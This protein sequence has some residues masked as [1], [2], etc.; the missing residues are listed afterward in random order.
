M[1]LHDISELWKSKPS[2]SNG[3]CLEN[4]WGLIAPCEFKSHGFRIMTTNT[5]TVTPQPRRK[6][7]RTYEYDAD[8]RMIR[9]TVEEFDEYNYNYQWRPDPPYCPPYIYPTITC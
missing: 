3:H 7:V 9:E 5:W 4:S 1:H 8:G 6:T 2:W